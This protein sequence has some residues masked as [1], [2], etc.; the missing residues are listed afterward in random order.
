M[1]THTFTARPVPVKTHTSL[2]SLDAN[3]AS[4]TAKVAARQQRGLSTSVLL[5]RLVTL[6]NDRQHLVSVLSHE[7]V[8][9]ATARSRNVV[10]NGGRGLSYV[11]PTPTKAPVSSPAAPALPKAWAVKIH[12]SNTV[13]RFATFAEA[14]FVTASNQAGRPYPM[15]KINGRWTNVAA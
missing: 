1:R 2:S 6:T 8:L 4:V 9:S 10:R 14:Q 5:A 3:I 7:T 11:P 13:L 12:G 15:V